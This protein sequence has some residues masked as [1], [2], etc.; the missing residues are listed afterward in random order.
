MVE[1]SFFNPLEFLGASFTLL[2]TFA[3]DVLEG[4]ILFLPIAFLT[5]D[6]LETAALF[7]TAFFL[8]FAVE[9]LT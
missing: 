7:T 1:R 3:L 9:G 5:G 8:N 4:I 6:F 2:C